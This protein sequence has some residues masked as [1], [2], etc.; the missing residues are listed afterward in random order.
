LVSSGL[1]SDS[2]LHDE[3]FTTVSPN[4]GFVLTNGKRILAH[5]D[6]ALV[7]AA[8]SEREFESLAI[9]ERFTLVTAFL[10]KM[11]EKRE[12]LSQALKADSGTPHWEA[13]HD[14]NA[15][16]RFLTQA[17]ENHAEIC[18]AMVAPCVGLSSEK[19]VRFRAI[20]TTVCFVPL[21]SPLQAFVQ[22]LVACA[23]SGSPVI[24]VGSP[25]VGFLTSLLSVFLRDAI[26][27]VSTKL[28][29]STQM[30]TLSFKDMK[31][32]LIDERIKGIVF[33]GSRASCDDIRKLTSRR[34]DI[35]LMLQ[36]GGKNAVIVHSSSNVGAAVKGALLGAIKGA[37]QLCTSTSR[38]IVYEN[39]L[40]EFSNGLKEAI[41]NLK[42]GNTELDEGVSMGPLYSEKAVSKFERFQTMA[43]RESQECIVQ[44]VRVDN[45]SYSVKPGVWQ[46][47]AYSPQSAY[48]SNVLFCP[49]LAVYSYNKFDQ[50]LE[51]ANATDAPYVVSYFGEGHYLT[52][53]RGLIDAPVLLHNLPTVELGDYY[54]VAGRGQSGNFRFH[55]YTLAMRLCYPQMEVI[56]DPESAGLEVDL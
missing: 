56:R 14:I 43:R 53:K 25:R 34:P 32:R 10:Q 47:G 18:Q 30:V 9:E 42:L 35:Q 1:R 5:F 52:H 38:V 26:S 48:Q 17:T 33:T 50:A 22:G 20:G 4:D 6:E 21:S 37:G 39:H 19:T 11:R 24:F 55:G 31:R 40:E 51:I 46:V 7:V 16:L 15:A 8:Q 13:Q 41:K 29:G 49:D 44:G 36:S 28:V 12:L 23:V 54:A 2:G 27:K 3:S 45:A